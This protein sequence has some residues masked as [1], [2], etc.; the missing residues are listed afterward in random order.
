MKLCLITGARSDWG[1]LEPLAAKIAGD[2]GLTLQIIVLGSHLSPEFGL[3]V[4]HIKHHIDARIECVL[5]SDSPTAVAKSLGLINIS[6]PE[7]FERLSPDAVVLL[8]DRC[9]ILSAATVAHLHNI[10]I[11]H[12]HGGEVTAAAVDDAFRHAITKMSALH[13]VAAE[14]YRQRVIQLGEDPARVFCVGAL[15]CSGLVKRK[16]RQLEPKQ[17]L[18]AYYPETI[19]SD[20][21]ELREIL[22]AVA[23]L[24]LQTV[25]FLKGCYD[26]GSLHLQ[27]A[28]DDYGVSQYERY[29]TMDRLLFLE[30]MAASDAIVGNSSS[31]IIE[32]PALG[33]PTINIGDRQK[34]RLMAGSI[35]QAEASRESVKAAFDRLYSA[36]FQTM[37]QGDYFTPYQGGDVAGKIIE[38]VKSELPGVELRKGFYDLAR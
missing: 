23:E 30:K 13:F 35:I 26:V 21:S 25:V 24:D 1:L 15:G 20:G 22:S 32:A 28:L 17:I 9:E 2:P 29:D 27:Y 38:I 34:G 16:W 7:A 4:N 14:P 5:S 37:M 36:D 6:L 8:G 11:I 31:G 19:W 33:V 18:L 3:T 10:P 12:I